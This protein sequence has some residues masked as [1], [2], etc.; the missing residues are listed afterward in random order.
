MKKDHGLAFKLLIATIVALYASVAIHHYTKVQNAKEDIY[1]QRGG[2]SKSLGLIDSL[3]KY[4]HSDIKVANLQELYQVFDSYQYDL[5]HAQQEGCVPRL[6]LAKLPH[7]LKKAHSNKVGKRRKEA[8]IKVV[9][10]LILQV[11]EQISN[12]RQKLLALQSRQKAGKSLRHHEKKFLINLAESYRSPSSKIDRLLLHV[13]IVPPSLALAQAIL[14]SGWGT[15]KA[16]LD[17][18]STFGHMATTTKVAAFESLSKNVISYIMNLN[19]HVAYSSF[20]KIRAN[21]RKQGKELCGKSLSAGLKKYSERGEA[22]IFDLCQLIK[23][24]SLQQYDQMTL[25]NFESFRLKP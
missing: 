22:Y 5:K 10:P 1:V 4:S 17:K 24:N 14:E 20:R 3:K 15:S 2:S 8:F 9:L 7:D 6:F 19:R 12:D 11:N 21:M 16:A 25:K 13:D 18:N 23:I